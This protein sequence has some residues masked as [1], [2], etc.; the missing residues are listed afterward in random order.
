MLGGFN[1]FGWLGLFG[2]FDWLGRGMRIGLGRCGVF[3]ASAPGLRSLFCRFLA[4]MGLGFRERGLFLFFA[5]RL[6]F[7]LGAS[8]VTQALSNGFIAVV[9]ARII[10]QATLGARI[11]SFLA[12]APTPLTGGLAGDVHSGAGIKRQHILNG[13][14][15][16]CATLPN[17]MRIMSHTISLPLTAR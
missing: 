12:N 16:V 2:R 15:A 4:D 14:I 1:V 6:Q 9:E 17:A 3:G 13:T 7:G 8:C 10:E 11:E 5:E